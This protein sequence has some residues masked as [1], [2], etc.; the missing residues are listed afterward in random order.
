MSTAAESM[1]AQDATSG[2]DEAPAVRKV[3]A[4]RHVPEANLE[5]AGSTSLPTPASDQETIVVLD[6][7]GQTSRLIARRIREANVYCEVLP[8]DAPWERIRCLNPKGLVL[9]GGPSSVYDENAPRCA[10]EVF[11]SDIPILGICYW[12]HLMTLE[13]GVVVSASPRRE[14]GPADLELITRDGVFADMPPTIR[15]WMSHGDSVD[16]PPPGFHSLAQ[17]SNSPFA[18]I[19]DDVGAVGVQFHP[20]LFDE[21]HPHGRTIL[22]N[23]LRL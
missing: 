4:S 5:A 9:S 8:H 2:V 15:V 14:Y 20:E 21:D 16:L 23:F 3:A 11:R 17:T 13:L 6:F 1:A 10:A 12:M 18:A 22:K 19:G 7:G